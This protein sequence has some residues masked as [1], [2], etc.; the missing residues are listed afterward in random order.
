VRL[1]CQLLAVLTARIGRRRE[2]PPAVRRLGEHAC[3]TTVAI[4]RP[5]QSW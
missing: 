4:V 3:T 1:P 2:N 5:L